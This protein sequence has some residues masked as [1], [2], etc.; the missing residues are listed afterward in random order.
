MEAQED[1]NN[2]AMEKLK[3]EVS[4]YWENYAA[5]RCRTL[6]DAIR[7]RLPRELRMMVFEA[8]WEDAHHMI[9]GWNRARDSTQVE[10]AASAIESWSDRDRVHCFDPRFVGPELPGEIREAWWRQSVFEFKSSDLIYPFINDDFAQHSIKN[11]MRTVVTDLYYREFNYKR[12]RPR[13]RSKGTIDTSKKG[14]DVDSELYCL[15]MLNR[16]TSIVVSIKKRDGRPSRNDVE[17]RQ[18]RF[19]TAVSCLFPALER[20]RQDGYKVTVVIGR[21]IEIAVGDSD[22]TVENWVKQ[23]H[24]AVEVCRTFGRGI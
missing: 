7:E 2:Q 13:S 5:S 6:C 14:T 17:A 24:A 22:I 8:L 4:S 20:L 9:T 10:E 15:H 18:H 21:D 19:L 16:N 1:L 12:A 3:S 23:I 11:K